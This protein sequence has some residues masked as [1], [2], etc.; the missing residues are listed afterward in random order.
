MIFF[1]KKQDKP[2]QVT[3]KVTDPFEAVKEQNK[4]DFDAL[5]YDSDIEELKKDLTECPRCGVYGRI[6]HKI[7]LIEV[8]E[9]REYCP[10]C[11]TLVRQENLAY[12]E[13]NR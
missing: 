11:T 9:V 7:R 13:H 5:K 10:D 2:K 8:D 1:R 12:R 6:M 3:S 4:K